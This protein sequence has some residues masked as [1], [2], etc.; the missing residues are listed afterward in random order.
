[1]LILNSSQVIA[2]VWYICE[3]F[4]FALPFICNVFY[5]LRFPNCSMEN[6]HETC[7]RGSVTFLSLSIYTCTRFPDACEKHPKTHEDTKHPLRIENEYR[8]LALCMLNL[9]QRQL[10]VLLA[11]LMWVV[12]GFNDWT[13]YCSKVF[14]FSPLLFIHI[15]Y[16]IALSLLWTTKHYYWIANIRMLVLFYPHSMN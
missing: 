3:W 15:L 9:R 2:T 14:F 7:I 12:F 11:K 13:T 8:C 6:M 4:N 10:S 1:M 16:Y 5:F